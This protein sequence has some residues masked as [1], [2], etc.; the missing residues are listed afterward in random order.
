MAWLRGKDNDS[1]GEDDRRGATG[2]QQQPGG[3]LTS[4]PRQLPNQ[5][6]W[7]PGANNRLNSPPVV[8]RMTPKSAS[9]GADEPEH[10]VSM[11]GPHSDSKLMGPSPGN[12]H[13]QSKKRS[14][15]SLNLSASAKSY[16]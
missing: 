12:H 16:V 3:V 14:T 8:V 7:R 15:L 2:P 13:K 4:A 1:I 11:T 6:R 5:E 10:H 9:F